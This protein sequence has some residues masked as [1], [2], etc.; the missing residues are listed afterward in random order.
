MT[1]IDNNHN[2]QSDLNLDL[3]LDLDLDSESVFSFDDTWIDDYTHDNHD[4]H[5]IHDK[6]TRIKAYF[7]YIEKDPGTLNMMNSNNITMI[8]NKNLYYNK[9]IYKSAI[10]ELI[11]EYRVN[12]NVDYNLYSILKYQNTSSYQDLERFLDSSSCLVDDNYLTVYKKLEDIHIDGLSLDI[13][14]SLTS[15]Y[16]I[17]IK[18]EIREQIKVAAP[19]KI[20]YS[21]QKYER[22]TRANKKY[23]KNMVN[24][25]TRRSMSIH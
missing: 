9:C 7:L 8:K 16:F 4:N 19:L 20:P 14:E 25:H 5:D 21:S 22:R 11:K 1:T 18:P 2:T 3:D 10:V 15:L 17:F 24:T 6:K 13:F 12:D 23:R